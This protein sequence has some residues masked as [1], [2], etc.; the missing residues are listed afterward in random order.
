MELL[1]ALF[2]KV[3][4]V[5]TF[6]AKNQFDYALRDFEE[7]VGKLAQCNEGA[8]YWRA[9]VERLRPIVETLGGEMAAALGGSGEG[10]EVGRA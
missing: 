10:G 6:A 9:E 5:S 4:R 1:I 8:K 3:G 7:A 2:A